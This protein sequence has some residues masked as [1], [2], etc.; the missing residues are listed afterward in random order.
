[1]EVDCEIVA[2]ASKRAGE[3]E[4]AHELNE[5]RF[6]RRDDDFADVRI[7]RDDGRGRGFDNV[8]DVGFRKS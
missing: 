7:A 1:M 5:R 3:L 8:A 4:I 2:A 6:L